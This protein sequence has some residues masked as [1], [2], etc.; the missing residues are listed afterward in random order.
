MNRILLAEDEAVLRMLISDTLED[1]GYEIEVAC[2]GE[3]AWGM[4]QAD[5]YDLLIL[6][7]MMPKLTGLEL[8][9]RVRE[10]DSPLPKMLMLSAKSQ[11]AEQD[12]VLAAG[13]DAFM[14]K[15]FSP[16]ELVKKVKELIHG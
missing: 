1:E 3:E 13:A 15:P 6:D 10:L 11:Q 16:N 7:Y 14:S 4:I 9:G 8:I 2:D 12:R 5:A